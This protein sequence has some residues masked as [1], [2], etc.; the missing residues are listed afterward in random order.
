MELVRELGVR[1]EKINRKAWGLFICSSCNSQVEK[2][3]RDGIRNKSCGKQVCR[4]AMFTPNALNSGNTKE[5]KISD[6]QYYS[7]FKEKYNYIKKHYTICDDWKTMQGFTDA[8]HASY[9]EA[10]QLSGKV[11]FS[12]NGLVASSETLSWKPIGLYNKFST[13]TNKA[14]KYIYLIEAAG[15]VKI[16]ITNRVGERV[17]QI[18]TGN[19]FTV[20]LLHA[21]EVS[22]ATEVEKALHT[23]YVEVNKRGEW[24]DLS[25]EQIEETIAY[26]DF[27]K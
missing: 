8:M 7:A 5:F 19:P 6:I 25:P 27:V 9:V 4:K 3:L 14:K 17:C 13:S 2:P 20:T 23:R 24:F 16:G 11:S 26:L 18:Q 15:Y 22:S 12:C 1:G 21:V 10:R